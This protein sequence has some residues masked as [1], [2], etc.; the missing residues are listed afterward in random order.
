MATTRMDS[1]LALSPAAECP[2]FDAARRRPLQPFRLNRT[3]AELSPQAKWESFYRISDF[4]PSSAFSA[5]LAQRMKKSD[6][7]LGP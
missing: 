5:K 6:A 7:P 4:I 3:N 2:T 1:H